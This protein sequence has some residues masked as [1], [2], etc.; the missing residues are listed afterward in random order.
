MAG[1]DA[2]ERLARARAR[3]LK[4]GVLL[5]GVY[6]LWCFVLIALLPSTTG[7]LRLLTMVGLLSVIGGGAALLLAGLLAVQRISRA[8]EIPVSVR[9]KSLIRVSIFL[10]PGVLLSGIVAF[11]ITR[12]PGYSIDI[13]RPTA[14]ADFV[15][16]LAVTMSVER[17][18]GI[19]SQRGLKPV[20]YVWD[21]EGDGKVNEETGVPEVTA[22]IDRQ[23]TYNVAMRIVFEDASFRRLS[24]RINIPTAVF[25]MSPIR[26]IVE[27]PVRFSISHLLPVVGSQNSPPPKLKEVQWDFDGDSTVDEIVKQPDIIHTFYIIG[28]VVV[29][30]TVILDNQSQVPYQRTVEIEKPSPPKFAAELLSEP[31]NLVGP[32]PFGGIFR[33][34]T[35]EPLREVQWSFGD[36]KEERGV[37]LKRIGHSFDSPGIYPVEA[38]LR[39]AS[40]EL[41]EVSA[42]VRVTESLSLVDL[43]FE[44]NVPING[45][46]ISAEAP[47]SLQLTPVTSAPL[48][49]FKWE[50]PEGNAHVDGKTL[51]AIYR[52]PGSYTVTLLA[53]DPEGRSLRMPLTV[54]VK[55]PS[56]EASIKLKPESGFAPLLVEFDASD[57]FVPAGE[58]VAGYAWLYGDEGGF[59]IQ[60]IPDDAKTDHVYERPGEYT[61][62]LQVITQSQKKFTAQRTILVRRPVIDSCFTASRLQVQSQKSVKFDA[63]C[64]TPAGVK[65]RWDVR[66]KDYPDDVLGQSADPVYIH[67]FEAPGEYEITLTVKDQEFEDSSQVT[68]TVTP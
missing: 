19:L 61:V 30:A 44:G 46:S 54:E 38:K 23:G 27:K 60:P 17:A 31:K 15:A 5:Y 66:S 32:A 35:K 4:G 14:A 12:E 68:I 50:A 45:K 10:L 42:L 22:V 53:Q 59:N 58:K 36:G 57:T 3:L 28:R 62:T 64:S 48:I 20:K 43:R 39:S 16:P 56:A 8:T 29:T 9:Q 6:V 52:R 25:S 41:V 2:T 24:R 55:P 40:G 21:F 51:R 18:A 13:V 26:P 47:V 37:D 1:G 67:L 49:E 34:E 33:I 65:L 7:G 11:M 63:S